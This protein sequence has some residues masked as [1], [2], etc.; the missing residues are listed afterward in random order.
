MLDPQLIQDARNRLKHVAV[1]TPLLESDHLNKTVGGR[2]FYKCENLQQTGSFKFRGAYN[3]I[4]A[5]PEADLAK[6]V[7]AYS[8][9]N[10][11]QGVAYAAKLAGVSAKI[12]MPQNAEPLK[13][14]RTQSYGAEVIFFDPDNDDRDQVIQN[15]KDETGA[16]YVS[17]FDDKL[18]IAGQA[19]IGVE[20][21]EQLQDYDVKSPDQVLVCCSGGGLIAGIGSGV[22]LHCPDTQLYSVE[23]QGYHDNKLS[24]AVGHILPKPEERMYTICDALRAAPP[25]EITFP[26]NLENGVSGLDVDD[27]EVRVAMRYAF[28]HLK[29]VVEPGGAVA[30]AAILHNK[31]ELKDKTTVIVLS[32]GNVNPQLYAEILN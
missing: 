19:T 17:P 15:L 27:D 1:K 4:R 6:G 23:A 30:L 29:L 25:G 28:H 16:T 31:L 20:I 18:V 32:G 12:I 22:K 11:A 3:R 26:I 2:I 14:E 8:T 10:H 21:A 7:I 24:L 9:G 5:I 13:V